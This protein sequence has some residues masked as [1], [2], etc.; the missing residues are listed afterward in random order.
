MTKIEHQSPRHGVA[1][2]FK[3]KNG[4]I[5]TGHYEAMGVYTDESIIIYE[6][7]H[8]NLTSKDFIKIESW[9]Y[10]K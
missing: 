4:E 8:A 5:L 10:T 1:C 3:M 6:K 9:E 2:K 7:H